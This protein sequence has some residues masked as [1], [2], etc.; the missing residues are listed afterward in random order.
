MKRAGYKTFIHIPI[1]VAKSLLVLLSN[2][3]IGYT[4]NKIL[5]ITLEIFARKDQYIRY[6]GFTLEII[7]N[8]L[9]KHFLSCINIGKRIHPCWDHISFLHY[10]Y[11]LRYI[12]LK[13]HWSNIV[14]VLKYWLLCFN[15]LLFMYLIKFSHTFKHT[16]SSI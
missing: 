14:L 11:W 8:K 6:S 16:S 2:S 15:C 5:A 1:M 10:E 4:L 13:Q 3:I 9:A 12:H 7:F